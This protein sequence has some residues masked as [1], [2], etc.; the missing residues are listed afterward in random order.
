MG[1]KCA[2]IG[3]SL[4]FSSLAMAGIAGEQT[5]NL[6]RVKRIHDKY[7]FADTHAHPSRFHRANVPKIEV[8]ELNRYKRALVD[9]VV[10]SVS[11]DA[12]YTGN[13]IERDGTRIE[14]GNRIGRRDGHRPEPGE[15]F[16]FTLD[17]LS[18]VLKSIEDGD[19]VLAS[20]PSAVMEA[21][22]QG[23]VALLP[24]LEGGDGLEADVENIRKLYD[25]GMRLLQLV[26]F[27]ANELG[28]I[29]TYPYSPGGLTAFGKEA[30]LESNRLGI[31]IDLAHANTETIMDTL[32]ISK[33][34]VL[35]SHTEA[36]ALQE[37]DRH[38]TDE[39]I[40]A[41]AAKGGIIGI[42]PSGDTLPKM[43]DMVRHIDYVKNLVGIDHVSIGSDLR[44][45]SSYTEG[46]GE[47]ANFLAIAEALIGHGYTD[48][49][50]GKVMGDN[51]MR[52]WKEVTGEK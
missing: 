41:I 29:Q 28:H 27:R 44:G 40:R 20:S 51:F 4:L 1:V 38:L 23:K 2:S 49:E 45:M 26:H 15:P 42:W 10:C 30:V 50:V 52:V 31:L 6:E 47:E 25:K 46:F 13:Y 11:T 36:K 37:G 17:R 7:V 24:A 9:V 33:H 3:L 35:F 18:R 16:A 8:E 5:E 43:E 21:R 34:P 14:G 48:E 32:D 39:E 19:A 22:K 12:I